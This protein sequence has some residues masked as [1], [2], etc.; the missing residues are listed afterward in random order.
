VENMKKKNN[1]KLFT[2]DGAALLIIDAQK[3]LI[4][5]IVN[6]EKI[7]ENI[8]KLI[9][10]SKIIKIPIIVTEQYPKGL[11]KTIENITDLIPNTK[12]I[13]KT[14]FN[15]FYSK[16][17]NEI[18]TKIKTTK[19]II[20]GIE[21]HICINQTVL[22]GIDDFEIYVISD[23]VSS[24]KLENQQIALDRMREN[25]AIISSTEMM[26][27]ELLIDAKTKEFKESLDLLK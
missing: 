5:K 25:G 21:T 4:D 17:F 18:I 1:Q 9:K 2:K 13:E 3:K 12:P 8:I 22:A 23:A 20:T 7:I 15:C 10:F 16:K 24:R 14:T 19:L 26:M 27:Y 11:G 6:K